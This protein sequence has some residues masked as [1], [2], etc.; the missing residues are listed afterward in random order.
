MS[1]EST[2]YNVAVVFPDGSG[3]VS[4]DIFISLESAVEMARDTA[5]NALSHLL[6]AHTLPNVQVFDHATLNVV[7][8]WCPPTI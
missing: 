8:E 4:E 7:W 3:E 6:H 2:M 1:T 5:G